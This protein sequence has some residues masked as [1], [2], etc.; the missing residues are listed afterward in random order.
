MLTWSRSK[1]QEVFL[2]WRFWSGYD[3]FHLQLTA[4]RDTAECPHLWLATN[5]EIVI[6]VANCATVSARIEGSAYGDS[7]SVALGRA[8]WPMEPSRLARATLLAAAA[9]FLLLY[10]LMGDGQ[11]GASRWRGYLGTVRPTGREREVKK[12]YEQAISTSFVA[13]DAMP[14]R[15][16]I[17]MGTLEIWNLICV[18]LKYGLLNVN[19]WF[20][21]PS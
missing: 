2:K 14:P 15:V 21:C 10:N 17:S 20:D 11:L 6:N 5:S 7:W 18:P 8:S 3:H 12:A 4:V 1:K 19:G 13:D 16:W 9:L